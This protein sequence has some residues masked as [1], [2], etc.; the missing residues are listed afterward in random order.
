MELVSTSYIQCDSW[1]D[2][3]LQSDWSPKLELESEVG[4]VG[5]GTIK[6][7]RSEADIAVLHSACIAHSCKFLERGAVELHHG[8]LDHKFVLALPPLHVMATERWQQQGD[9]STT[10]IKTSR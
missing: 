10:S 3:R 5:S 6:L 4:V 2:S 8:L 1:L 9:G 7:N